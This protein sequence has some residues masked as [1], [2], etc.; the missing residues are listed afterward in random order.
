[1]KSPEELEQMFVKELN[2][3]NALVKV[4]AELRRQ[5]VATPERK[6][7]AELRAQCWEIDDKLLDSEE[8]QQR[9][10]CQECYQSEVI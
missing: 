3:H 4:R 7:K 8:R 6:L 10:F 1:M 5:I 2:R 9:I